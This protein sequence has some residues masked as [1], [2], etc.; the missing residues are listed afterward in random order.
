MKRIAALILSIVYMAF[1]FSAIGYSHS[2]A[3]FTH[4]VSDASAECHD[5][6]DDNSCTAHYEATGE[7]KKAPKHQASSGK[8]KVP[9]AS[10]ITIS[11]AD[12]QF[13]DIDNARSHSYIPQLKISNFTDLYLRN[14]VLLI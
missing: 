10:F 6:T 5:V 1:T 12:R 13:G 4:A 3:V 9:R 11:L 14:R 7:F 2:N 8:I